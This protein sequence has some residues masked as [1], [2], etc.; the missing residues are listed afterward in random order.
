MSDQNNDPLVKMVKEAL[1]K[2]AEEIKGADI[3]VAV[4]GKKVTLKGVVDSKKEGDMAVKIA[5]Q[6]Q[7]VE[8]VMEEFQI[9]PKGELTGDNTG[10]PDVGETDDAQG[11]S[12][13]P[14]VG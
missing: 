7:G 1:Q 3:C 12:P 14:R 11:C 2:H 5:S 4:S 6:V 9:M 13:S 10:R 8:S